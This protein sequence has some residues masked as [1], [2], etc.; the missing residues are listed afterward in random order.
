MGK[1]IRVTYYLT[2]SEAEQD[3]IT[4]NFG[5]EPSE[6]PILGFARWDV[7]EDASSREHPTILLMPTWRNWL[8]DQSREAFLQSEYYKAYADFIQDE[9]TSRSRAL[10]DICNLVH[11]HHKG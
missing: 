2:T 3:V 5:Y 7:L 8:E 11:L 9:Q 10:D 6:A 4:K 1:G